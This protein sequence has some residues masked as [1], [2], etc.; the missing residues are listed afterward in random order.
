ML[1]RACRRLTHGV[2]KIDELSPHTPLSSTLPNEVSVKSLDR[3]DTVAFVEQCERFIDF[4]DDLRRLAKAEDSF[5]RTVTL[6]G[7][8]KQYTREDVAALISDATHKTVS[9]TQ[10]R[11][12]VFRFKPNGNQSDTCF[13]LLQSETDAFAVIKAVQE[14]AVPLRRVYGTSFGCSFVY[15][16]RSFLFLTDSAL[17]YA[18]EDGSKRSWVMTLGW[19]EDL[20]ADQLAAVLTSMAIYP[21]KIV[22]V[23]DGGRFLLRFDRTKNAKLVFTR[24]NRLKHRW[25]IPANVPFFA[26][27]VRADL[28][29]EGDAKHADEASDCDSDLDEPVMY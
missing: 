24:L 18:I 4:T 19:D 6:T 5:N 8:P 13:V 2:P 7:V 12:V 28:H 26:Y 16:D 9:L 22:K 23:K 27:P 21:N 25:R 11:D 15:A 10:L 14:F 3:T 29:F 17:D 20:D 1:M